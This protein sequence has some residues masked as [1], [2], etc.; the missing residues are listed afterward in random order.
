MLSSSPTISLRASAVLR[1]SLSIEL[2]ESSESSDNP[3]APA[4]SLQLAWK[5]ATPASLER[6]I[7]ALTATPSAV[8]RRAERSPTIWSRRAA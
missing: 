8:V 2:L 6:R 1:P 3:Y 7:H 4:L 5:T